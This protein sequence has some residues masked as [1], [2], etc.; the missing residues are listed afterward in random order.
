MTLNGLPDTRKIRKTKFFR[1]I[2]Q[3]LKIIRKRVAATAASDNGSISIWDD[4]NG[5]WR[6]ERDVHFIPRSHFKGK[7]K[8]ELVAWLK[9]ELPKIN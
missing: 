5:F 6:A 2:P 4:R 9:I 8:R 1:T 3:A 7:T